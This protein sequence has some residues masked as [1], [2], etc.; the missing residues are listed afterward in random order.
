MSEQGKK[1]GH[2]SLDTFRIF[3]YNEPSRFVDLKAIIH[4]FEIVESMDR[5]HLHGFAMVYD[6]VGLLDD[7]LGDG[8]LRGE[9]ELLISYR[10]WYNEV[11]LEHKMFVYS[12]TDVKRVNDSNESMY[13]YKLHFVSRDKFISEQSF[14]RRGYRNQLI[15]DNVDDVFNDFY[16]DD[17]DITIQQT[18]G[19]QTLV[20]PNLKPEQAMHFFARRAYSDQTPSQAFRFFENRERFYFATH[21]DLVFESSGEEVIKYKRWYSANDQTPEAQSLLMLSIIDIEYP[22]HVNTIQDM[23]D[24]AYH[25]TLTELDFLNRTVFFNQYQYLDEYN[26]Q[27]LPDGQNRVRSKHSKKFVDEYMSYPNESL[28]V[29]DYQTPD[30]TGPGLRPN[31]YYPEVYNNKRV[32]HYHHQ[33]E[34]ITIKIHGNNTVF[35][36]SIIE[37]E[38]N[39]VNNTQGDKGK[40]ENRSGF[41]LVESARNVFYEENYYQILSISKSGFK[42][43]PESASD[44]EN[45]RVTQ[46]ISTEG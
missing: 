15:S 35:A 2:Y 13:S 46:N 22:Q 40:E 20:V 25:R 10:D 18:T 43:R 30:N 19:N 1:A 17:K 39:N 14:I 7:F 8:W 27:L 4:S 24:G 21:E 6:S 5:G 44:Y 9:E 31:T 26:Q 41:Y 37:L 45:E 3:R 16:S 33:N 23:N 29:K 12:I 42:G 32:A 38:L 36:G 11:T 34:L 28:V